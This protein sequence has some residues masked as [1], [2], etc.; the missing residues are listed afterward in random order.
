MDVVLEAGPTS[1]YDFTLFKSVHGNGDVRSIGGPTL[2][3]DG[4]DDR[5]TVVGQ[6]LGFEPFLESVGN[7]IFCCP[8]WIEAVD[9]VIW[10]VKIN[11]RLAVGFGSKRSAFSVCL[12][13][14][15]DFQ[16]FCARSGHS[17]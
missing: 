8:S 4:F 3:A 14:V 15:D 17:N 16:L 9:G 5:H 10:E 1:V 12:Q 13:K 11:C 7:A 2:N 6:R